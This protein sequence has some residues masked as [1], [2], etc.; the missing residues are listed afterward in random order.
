VAGWG[1]FAASAPSLA[2]AGRRLL[3]ATGIAFLATVRRDGAP[4]LHPIVPIFSGDGLYV[5]VNS[6]SPKRHDLR[7]DNRYALHA[8]LGPDDEEFALNG[9]TSEVSDPA[10]REMIIAAASF[11][12]HDA[13]A[14]FELRVARCL[15][16]VWE[17][18][19]QPDTQPVRQRWP[20]E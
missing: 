7:R 3:D 11:T 2:T 12:V 9:M 6:L 13:D 15:H 14:L 18:V 16:T 17:R 4:R 8:S 20:H 19:G 5:A 10:T 1:A